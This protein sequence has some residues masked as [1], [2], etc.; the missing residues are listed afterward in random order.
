LGSSCGDFPNCPLTAFRIAAYDDDM[1]VER[2]EFIGG[3]SRVLLHLET[4]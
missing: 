1:N 4:S 3:L 2:G